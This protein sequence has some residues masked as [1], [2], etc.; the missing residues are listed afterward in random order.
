MW[1]TEFRP[2]V[3]HLKSIKYFK[4]DGVKYRNYDVG[5]TLQTFN[6]ESLNEM[7]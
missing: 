7:Q 6:L 1:A 3:V 2:N 4:N 5:A